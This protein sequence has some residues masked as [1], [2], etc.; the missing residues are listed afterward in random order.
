MTPLLS[1]GEM[2][3]KANSPFSDCAITTKS[4]YWS[5]HLLILL[6]DIAIMK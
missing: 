1:I 3:K 2:A 4:G 6:L 5:Q